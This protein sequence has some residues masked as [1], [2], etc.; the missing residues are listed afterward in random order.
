[1]TL[2]KKVRQTWF[3]SELPF[4]RTL[5]FPKERLQL[6]EPLNEPDPKTFYGGTEKELHRLPSPDH[7]VKTSRHHGIG[8]FPE[9]TSFV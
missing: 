4:S 2:F 8:T 5:I 7:F 3:P 9:M 1:M 6:G